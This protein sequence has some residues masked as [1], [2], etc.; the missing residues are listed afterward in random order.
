M[1]QPIKLS[2]RGRGTA[3]NPPNRFEPIVFAWDGDYL[4]DEEQPS[5][6]TV[7]FKDTSRS[8]IVKNDSPDVGFTYSINPFRGCC[9]GCM[10][11]QITHHGVP[12]L[13]INSVFCF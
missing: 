11:K 3:D 12:N 5:P 10:C 13:R 2:I 6:Q 8:I 7:Y 4:D 1:T 9:H